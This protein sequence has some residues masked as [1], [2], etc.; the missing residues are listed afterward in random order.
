MPR[1]CTIVGARPQFIKAAALSR[2]IAN[3]EGWEQYILHTGQHYD[4]QLSD[5][6]FNS[7][8]IPFPSY[9]VILDKSERSARFEEMKGNIASILKDDR[10]DAVLVYGDTDSTLA[11]AEAAKDLGINIIHVEAGL[12]S[13]DLDM[14]EEVNRIATDKISDILVAPTKTAVQNLE[15]EG[16]YGAFLTGDI[17]HDNAVY[18]SQNEEYDLSNHILLTMHRPSNVDSPERAVLWLETIGSWCLSNK[19][20]AVFLVHPRTKNVLEGHYGEGWKYELKE[21]GV[22]ALNPAGYIEVLKLIKAVDLVVTDSGGLQK[23]AYSLCKASVVIRHNTEWVELIKAGHAMLC[24][25]P[26]NFNEVAD[27]QLLT[28]VDT[29]DNLYGDGRAAEHILDM[30]EE[31]L[32]ANG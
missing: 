20:R 2:A 27:S 9:K 10:P 26:E 29:S 11:G 24:P 19:L 17:M 6:F 32:V 31:K 8:D 28:K 15:N 3:R 22:E 7:L 21:L 30:L 13:F 1:I 16:I 23:E 14:P 12:R 18:Y 5:V 25:E 4:R